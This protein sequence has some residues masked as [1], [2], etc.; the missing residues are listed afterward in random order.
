MISS[1]MAHS[2]MRT[3]TSFYAYSWL[4]GAWATKLKYLEKTL[5][6]FLS[7]STFWRY[8]WSLSLSA[9]PAALNCLRYFWSFEWDIMKSSMSINSDMDV[10]GVISNM[11]LTASTFVRTMLVSSSS[12]A[13]LRRPNGA[14]PFTIVVKS[15]TA[16]S[17]VTAIISTSPSIIML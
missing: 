3:Q 12:Y 16:P 14:H 13:T 11:L 5:S 10:N 17:L 4:L 1:T 7:S 2:G 9:F 6:S 8:N 15:A